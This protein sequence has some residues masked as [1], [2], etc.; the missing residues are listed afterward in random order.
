M[1]KLTKAGSPQPA[2]V[3]GREPLVYRR[4]IGWADTDAARIVYTVRF[5]DFA[6]T[7]IE[8][9]FREVYG[10]DWYRMHTEHG[11]GTPFVHVDMDIRA[12][13]VPEDVLDVTVLVEAVGRSTI[14]FAVEGRRG[15]GERS[16]NAR[17]TCAVVDAGRMKAV[18]IPADR[19]RRIEA[20]LAACERPG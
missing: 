6:L 11:M 20:Y 17:Y 5:F 15:D 14:G 18:S 9:W 2:D 13:L 10:L 1:S 12:P 4:R 3:V 19:R 16:F 8:A 7:A